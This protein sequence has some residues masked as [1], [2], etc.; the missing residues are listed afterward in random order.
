M[1][2][3][4]TIT[5]STEVQSLGIPLWVMQWYGNVC[6]HNQSHLFI[7]PHRH[8]TQNMTAQELKFADFYI[9]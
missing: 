2:V 1:F 8:N 6:A 5:K 3:K 4:V 9:H 7:N